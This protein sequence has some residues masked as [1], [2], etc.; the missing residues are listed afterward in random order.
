MLRTY[1]LEEAIDAATN[2]LQ[3]LI[4]RQ[5]RDIYLA[6]QAGIILGLKLAH[7]QSE[8]DFAAREPKDWNWSMVDANIQ[9]IVYKAKYGRPLPSITIDMEE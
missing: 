7:S 1:S 2:R 8:F 6:Q 4:Q 5:D 3:Q 9:Q